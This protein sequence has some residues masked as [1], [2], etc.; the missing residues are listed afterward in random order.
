MSAVEHE[1][2][3][4]IDASPAESGAKRF[5]AAISSIRR[6]VEGLE[7][8][9]EGAFLALKNFKPQFDVT[10]ITKATTATRDLA[11][12]LTG[13]S[14][15]STKVGTQTQQAALAASMAL[16]Q[17]STSAQKL[18]FRLGDLQQTA[19]LDQLDAGL[20]RL[21]AQLRRAPDVAAVRVA[22]SA[23]ED[24]RVEL[25]QSATA[26][27]YAKGDLAQLSREQAAAAQAAA[28]HSNA[29]E[30]LALKY[31]PL[32]ANSLAYAQSL[33]EISRAE[34]AG[35]ITSQLAEQARTRAAQ[36]LVATTTAQDGFTKSSGASGAAIA[37]VSAQFQ[38][39]AVMMAAGQNPFQLAMQQGTQLSAVLNQMGGRAAILR[40]LASGFMSMI[41][42]VS[43][44]TIG[45]IL[46]GSAIVNWMTSG[47]EATMTFS[48]ALSQA[49]T[50][51]SDMNSA[52]DTLTN[53]K[54]GSLSEA[55]GRVNEEMRIHLER[56]AQ[57]SQL[58]AVN[59]NR[60]MA[61]S[62][63]AS[64]TGGWLTNDVDDVRIAL[65]TTNDSARQ[66][67]GLLA[68]IKQARTFAE[69]A[70]A[71]SAARK[72]LESMGIT[73]DNAEGSAQSVLIQLIKSED[74]ALK[75]K[76]AS[77]E[78]ASAIAGAVGQTGAWANAMAGVRMEINAILS[79]LS[80]IG[81]G[82]ISNAAKR[83]EVTALQAGQTVRQAEVAR[84]RFE[85]EQK[86]TA[87]EMG[88]GS[89]VSGWAQRQLIQ[90]ERFQ[91]DEG[92]RLDDQLN[93][94][95]EAARKRETSS[96]GG[97]GGGGGGRTAA[98]SEEKTATDELTKSLTERLTSLDEERTVLGL[99]ASGMFKTTEAAELFA[100]AQIQGGGAVDAQTAAMIAQ[101]DAAARLNEEL[102]KAAKD[103][104]KEWM[105]S[106]PNWLEAG[107]QIEM[108]A[109]DSLKG[110]IS[111][112]IKTGKFDI[113]SLGE[114]ILGTIADIVAD[115]A[116]KELMTMFGRG[117]QSATGGF[118]GMLA[119][120]F[121]S[122][123]DT[124]IAMQ[125]GGA[126]AGASI[127]TS[128]TQAGAQVAAQIQ[129]AMTGAGA[130]AG[131]SVQSG[132]ATGSVSVRSA[133]QT[134]LAVG[135]TNI[136]LAASTGGNTLGQ[137][138]VMGAQQGAPI[139]AQGVAMG[140][141]GGGGGGGLLAGV[142]GWGGLLSMALG[143]FSEGGYSTSP[144]GLASAPLAAFANAPH[145]AQGTANTSGI[146][147]ILHE[148]EAVIPLSR[149]RKIP[150]ELGD[151]AGSNTTVNHFTWN[152]TTPNPD[153]FRKSQNQIA[154]DAARMGQRG[155]AKNG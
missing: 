14:T 147:A 48:D 82:V 39:V 152:I 62:L 80:A 16:R 86:M 31:N 122:E 37:N 88:A 103:P 139:L 97:G 102:T 59:A 154:A 57:I 91:F 129:A 104:V 149:G 138:V 12:A 114:A 71:I 151:S 20:D 77:E 106:V 34:Q 50:A 46:A 32:R 56:L 101:I 1:L 95:R 2:R 47:S 7:K 116:V 5:T 142:G 17:A 65:D 96:A 23:Y 141:A 9:S 81:G 153:A 118:A 21:H 90:M 155:L 53:A 63:E 117:E 49:N 123:G 35:M 94:Q 4:K 19:S 64:M 69:Q 29:L 58:E 87:K 13:A 145:Y 112:M 30:A 61:A 66:F 146:P 11:T 143:A 22:R 128:M 140:A 132:L 54:L 100:K 84:L 150:V 93:A 42:P 24:L 40:T 108:G 92:I 111:E 73:L 28:R 55:Y 98:L 119:G 45:V 74:A 83:A 15:A 25:T 67:L 41:N 3:V 133:A 126:S 27:E 124:D 60:D 105:D 130:Q 99:V 10:P 110:A 135:A 107:K 43:L 38:D 70:E 125:T 136:R 72:Y 26:A 109:I 131:M 76:N 6:A 79:S 18:A 134:G 51:I 121:S 68:S 113:E 115:K 148:N 137:G 52:T 120:L 85:N 144:V 89:G 78:S 8:D 33:E 44:L 127:A 36:S 75:L